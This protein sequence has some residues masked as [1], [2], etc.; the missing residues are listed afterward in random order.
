MQKTLK[1]KNG[2]S[3]HQQKLLSPTENTSPE[4]PRQQSRF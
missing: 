4:M 1:V 2:Q 3:Q